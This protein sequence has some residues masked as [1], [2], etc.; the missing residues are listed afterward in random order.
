MHITYIMAGAGSMYCG[1]CARDL[2]LLRGLESR[3][4]AALAVPLYT[5]IRDDRQGPLPPMAP[6]F[7]GGVNVYLQQICGLFRHTPRVVDA[8]FDYPALLRW[9][10]HFAIQ[11]DAKALGP[12]TV[13]V[14]AGEAG[15]QA[16]ELERLVSWLEGQPKPDVINITNTLLS[17]LAPPLKA[18]LGV[19]VACTLQGEDSF[20]EALLEPWQED[21]RRLIRENAQAID[22]FIAPDADYADR[23]A[24][25]LAVPRER[26]RVVPAG[27]DL[28]GFTLHPRSRE[29]FTIGFLSSIVRAKGLD[30]LVEALRMLHEH[31]IDARLL[32]AGR[33]MD[34]NYWRGIT[35]Q[36]DAADL[37][38][39]VTYLDE[40]DFDEKLDFLHR[41]SVFALPSR[42]RESRG[43]AVLEAL[44][45]GVPVVVPDTGVFR[46]MIA[47]TR[48]GLAIPPDNV[49]ALALALARLHDHPDEAD[50][51]AAAG[52]ANVR[53]RYSADT[54]VD[55]VLEAYGGLV[56]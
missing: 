45:A 29:P 11:T 17:A 25:F 56:E 21:A 22:L 13:S 49:T 35:A 39:S 55:R 19:P 34:A 43:I 20:V 4:H 16:K 28:A 15:Y 31:A 1:A 41:C 32:I 38:A 50:A 8:L 33:V 53:R 5:P 7:F 23:M 3:G 51:Y 24:D 42:L 44:A 9:V 12:M 26:I 14:L 6:I 47:A 48:G 52:A 2:A 46:E 30:L 10:S 18:R 37:E 27:I 40:V 36:I 54:M